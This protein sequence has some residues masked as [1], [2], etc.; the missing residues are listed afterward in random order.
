LYPQ[1]TCIST[2]THLKS[3][4][5]PNPDAVLL[6]TSVTVSEKEARFWSSV[7]YSAHAPYIAPAI[8]KELDK[9][10]INQNISFKREGK[11]KEKRM[12]PETTGG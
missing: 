10:D 9:D 12:T 1:S 4:C 5:L 2:G 8:K 7:E 3:K 6:W 11:T